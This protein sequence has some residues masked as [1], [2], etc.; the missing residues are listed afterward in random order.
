MEQFVLIPV[1]LYDQQFKTSDT[2]TLKVL[3][4]K[5]QQIEPQIDIPSP[6][7]ESVYKEINSKLK[8]NVNSFT[9]KILSSPRIKISDSNK[10]LLDGRDTGVSIVDFI[11]KLKRAGEEFPDIYYTLL[12]ALPNIVPTNVVN[13]NAKK[14][15]RGSWIPFKI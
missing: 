3:D 6:N 1:S 2:S 4:L 5:E 14:K 9:N 15:D 10:I 7:L 8:S 13:K 11:H 12:D